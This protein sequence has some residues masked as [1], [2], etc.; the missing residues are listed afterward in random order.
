M[1]RWSHIHDPSTKLKLFFDLH[2]LKYI[3]TLIPLFLEVILGNKHGDFGNVPPYLDSP[4]QL[5]HL[6]LSLQ[7]DG[8]LHGA[9]QHQLPCH[10]VRT[11]HC[12]VAASLPSPQEGEA[13]SVAYWT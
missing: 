4:L 10:T 1:K 12:E 8:A 7:H 5:A 6:H 9:H 11:L 3:S 2:A 13:K